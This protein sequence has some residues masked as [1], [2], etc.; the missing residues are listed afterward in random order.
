MFVSSTSWVSSFSSAAVS[1]NSIPSASFSVDFPFA[2]S[3]S[4]NTRLEH[5]TARPFLPELKSQIHQI[6]VILCT[7]PS[8]MHILERFPNFFSFSEQVECACRLDSQIVVDV[9]LEQCYHIG[10]HT[11]NDWLIG[12]RLEICDEGSMLSGLPQAR[13]VLVHWHPT[14]YF[15]PWY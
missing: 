10:L 4:W 12:L 1:G 3:C 13:I 6:L 8:I 15:L 9:Q 2:F 7:Y 11:G 5:S 14:S